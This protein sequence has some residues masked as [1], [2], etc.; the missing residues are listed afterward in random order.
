[1]LVV[2][3]GSAF[4]AAFNESLVNVALVSIMEEFG[5]TDVTAQWLVTGYMIVTAITIT[6][7]AFL[8]K[9]FKLRSL[10]FAAS[11]L[12][13]VGSCI[14]FLAPSFSVLLVFR[15]IQAMGTGI[16]IPV[17]MSTVLIVAPPGR[18]GTY[19]A[20]GGC[21]TTLGPACA[22][23]IAGIMVTMI[24]W[25]TVFLLPAALIVVLAIA[26][27]ILVKDVNKP[28]RIKLDVLSVIL[29]AFGLFL[30][31]YGLSII[32]TDVPVAVVMIIA[33]AA[34]IAVFAVRQFR[35]SSPVLN[36]RP[37]RNMLFT[38]TCFLILVAMMTSF[39]MSVM[40]PLYYE[41]SLGMTSFMAGIMLLVPILVNA[42]TAVFGGRIL[43]RWGCWPLLPCGYGTIFVAY[44]VISLTASQMSW[45][46]ILVLSVF[47]Y[48]S[49]G[50]IFSPT[51]TSGLQTLPPDQNS[52][53]VALLN[54]FVQIAASVGPSLFVGILS[55]T[56]AG[57]LAGGA[58]EAA[59][60]AAGFSSAI[61]VASFIALAGFVLAFAYARIRHARRKRG[62]ISYADVAAAE[63]T[64]GEESNAK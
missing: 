56:A 42:L 54:I 59:S 21:M 30:F 4:V 52:D 6:I 1:M 45:L 53:G 44:V 50:I 61:F 57:S 31:V 35:I 18:L 9:R 47:V 41:S 25:R 37:L 15:L 20:V 33:G 63:G 8:Y 3:Y 26:G 36:L 51:Q 58:T 24:G 32:T 49:V 11:L 27:L 39:S 40:L 55:S 23:V 28:E 46:V 7:T 12:I 14:C 43:D 17:M 34:V 19:L 64:Q 62:L 16:F 60:Q 22:P 38:P 48:G 5:I 2:L 29:A 13:I 10:F